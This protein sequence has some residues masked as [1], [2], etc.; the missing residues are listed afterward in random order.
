MNTIRVL[1]QVLLFPLPWA[2]RRLALQSLFG[3]QIPKSAR[4]G[5]SIILAKRLA[6]ADKAHISNLV[7]CKDIDALVMGPN[8]GIM[9]LNYI[10]GYP[11]ETKTFF[12]DETQRR[13]ELVL[14]DSVAITSRQFIDCNGGVYIDDYA[15]IA[16]LRT[17]IL[18][19]SVNVHRNRQETHPVRI[20]KY[21][22]VGTGCII[23]PGAMLPD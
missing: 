14:G 21:C 7:F 5:L 10:T 17:Q 13:C 9:A 16:G 1:I 15:T 19:H 22:F 18:T 2:V 12:A 8:S 20:G 11:S 4:V 23:L 6:M 3:Y